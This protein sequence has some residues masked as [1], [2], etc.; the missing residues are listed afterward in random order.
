MGEVLKDGEDKSHPSKE[1]RQI[2]FASA[3]V[4]HVVNIFMFR[5]MLATGQDLSESDGAALF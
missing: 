4:Q 1:N 3:V 2:V 5:T